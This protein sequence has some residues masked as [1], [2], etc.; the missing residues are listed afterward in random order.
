MNKTNIL[1][2][3]ELARIQKKIKQLIPEI[4]SCFCFVLY[5]RGWTA[6]QIEDLFAETQ[7]TWNAN[8]DRM[9]TMIEWCEKETGILVAGPDCIGDQKGNE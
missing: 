2:A 3:R 9:D 5:N 6:E 7:E 4:Y 8:A 1:V